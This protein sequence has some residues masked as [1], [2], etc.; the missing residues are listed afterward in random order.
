M[1]CID[2][3]CQV[4]NLPADVKPFLEFCKSEHIR[5]NS[6]ISM[7][8]A[9][10]HRLDHTQHAANTLIQIGSYLLQRRNICGVKLPKW[11][12]EKWDYQYHPFSIQL[13]ADE[14]QFTDANADVC[15]HGLT[16][17]P[18][19]KC[20]I[21]CV[22]RQFSRWCCSHEPR[23]GASTLW[24]SLYFNYNAL[25]H[26]LWDKKGENSISIILANGLLTLIRATVSSNLWPSALTDIFNEELKSEED[27]VD[28]VTLGSIFQTR[29]QGFIY[30]PVADKK[31][32][33]D[34]PKHIVRMHECEWKLLSLGVTHDVRVK[35]TDILQQY[36]PNEPVL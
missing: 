33:C 21:N 15:W 11:I 31:L 36:K 23:D 13:V 1:K 14:L 8:K 32:Q 34:D 28:A 5:F 35:L 30:F 24:L 3:V 4:R 9:H 25:K 27:G 22:L 19:L 26:F 18:D 6:K 29:K 7:S 17:T 20:F 12:D 2:A 10:G 16:L